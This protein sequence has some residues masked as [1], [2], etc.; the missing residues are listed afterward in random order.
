MDQYDINID[1][2]ENE[3]VTRLFTNNSA[4]I[5]IRFIF[6]V[7]GLG[8]GEYVQRLIR[9]DTEISEVGVNQLWT[10]S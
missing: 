6:Y 2:I 9:N 8:P 4:N 10:M 3:I 7:K 1:N 5:G